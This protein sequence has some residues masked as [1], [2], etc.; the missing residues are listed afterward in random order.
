[1][2]V[3]GFEGSIGQALSEYAIPIGTAWRSLQAAHTGFYDLNLIPNS[4]LEEQK[5]FKL[6]WHGWLLAGLTMFSIVFFYTS[7]ISRN[8]EI[9]A[10]QELLRRRQTEFRDLEVLR[11]QRDTLVRGIARFSTAASVYDSI[12]PGGDRWSRI[13][14]YISNS[15]D[16][17]NSLW[18]YQITQDANNQR[19][20]VVSGRSIYR[21]RIPRLASL[22]EKATLKA[23]RTTTIRE[24]IVYEFDLQVDQIDKSDFRFPPKPIPGR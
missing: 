8:Q 3:S 5:A 1:V 11:Q 24:K 6:A 4:I 20:L 14:H 18:V 13:L 2:D 22:F 17:L 7:I 23:V 15:V 9:R 12:A 21:T 19:S 10:A 16:D